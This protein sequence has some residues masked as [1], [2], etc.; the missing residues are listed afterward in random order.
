[1]AGPHDGLLRVLRGRAGP[2]GRVFLARTR[3]TAPRG[4]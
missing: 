3:A 1:M 4:V 2:G